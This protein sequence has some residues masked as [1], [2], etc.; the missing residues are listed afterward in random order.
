MIQTPYGPIKK[1]LLKKFCKIA[2]YVYEDDMWK[3]VVDQKEYW[4][5]VAGKWVKKMGKLPFR[6]LNF[7]YAL[8]QVPGIAVKNASGGTNKEFDIEAALVY[9]KD[10]LEEVDGS[11]V[12]LSEKLA[13]EAGIR[14]DVKPP[15][16]CKILKDE[17]EKFKNSGY[18]E[19]NPKG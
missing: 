18:Q 12:Y 1:S 6:D 15:G 4:Q 13:Q 7:Q 9:A 16:Y 19:A 3:S 8:C 10:Y 11:P 17:L 2:G 5:N 14:G